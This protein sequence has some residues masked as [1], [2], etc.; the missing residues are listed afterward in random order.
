MFLVQSNLSLLPFF[1][2]YSSR[3][4]APNY[5]F[6]F[7][8]LFKKQHIYIIYFSLSLSFSSFSSVRIESYHSLTIMFAY[9]VSRRG[10]TLLKKVCSINSPRARSHSSLYVSSTSAYIRFTRV[11]SFIAVWCMRVCRWLVLYFILLYPFFSL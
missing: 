6:F 4:L 11:F 3:P 9:A 2:V 10:I 8:S 7:L 5:S 1:I